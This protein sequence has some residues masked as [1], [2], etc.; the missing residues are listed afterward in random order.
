MLAAA[1]DLRNQNL[2]L[3][4]IASRVVYSY[5]IKKLLRI[6]PAPTTLLH[7][8]REHDNKA[9]AEMQQQVI[10]EVLED[11]GYPWTWWL[12]GRTAIRHRPR[13]PPIQKQQSSPN[14]SES[15]IGLRTRRPIGHSHLPGPKH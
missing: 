5:G 14:R 1:L 9:I 11:F 8:L 6:H 3:E 15:S 2:S 12:S 10:R 13:R 7:M 4:D